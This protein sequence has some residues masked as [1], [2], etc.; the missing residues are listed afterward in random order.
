MALDFRSHEGEGPGNLFTL[1]VL[2]EISWILMTMGMMVPTSLPLVAMFSRMTAH[3]PRSHF[4]V[5]ALLSGYLGIWSVVGGVVYGLLG[6]IPL[7]INGSGEGNAPGWIWAAV[8]CLIA[9][10]YQLSSW[11]YACL[12]HCRSPLMF[13]MQ[14]WKGSQ[15]LVG[16]MGLGIRHG[17]WCIGCCWLLMI[18]LVV[19]GSGNIWWMLIF[20]LAMGLEKN[21]FWG[22]QLSWPIGVFLLVGGMGIGVNGLWNG[23][24]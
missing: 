17:L 18:V 3:R 14:H 24:M 1:F 7:F 12:D 21:A 9:G 8:A 23:I 20:G 19:L 5:V 11:K 4:W 2:F 22:P 16:A 6:S 10:G 15:P 13:L